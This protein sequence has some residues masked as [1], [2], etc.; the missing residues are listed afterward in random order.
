MLMSTAVAIQ[1]EAFCCFCK[2][3]YNEAIREM[4]VRSQ[5]ARVCMYGWC[6][7]PSALLNHDYKIKESIHCGSRRRDNEEINLPQ[8]Q[9][10]DSQKGVGRCNRE[11]I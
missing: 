3:N 8:P 10:L 6:V 9:M 2:S 5:G 4:K 1:N 11:Q 7:F